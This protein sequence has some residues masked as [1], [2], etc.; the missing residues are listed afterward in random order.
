MLRGRTTKSRVNEKRALQSSQGKDRRC[1]EAGQAWTHEWKGD[2]IMLPPPV[3]H[4]VQR[5]AQRAPLVRIL[6]QI[7]VGAHQPLQGNREGGW[8]DRVCWLSMHAAGGCRGRQQA[9]PLRCDTRLHSS[10]TPQR[11]ARLHHMPA[12]R[13]RSKGLVRAYRPGVRQ[14]S[15]YTLGLP[16]SMLAWKA[17][18]AC[19]SRHLSG[20]SA[21]A[22]SLRAEPD[23]KW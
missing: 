3:P 15:P 2:P 23:R 9:K 21:T 17:S 20:C 13:R 18:L 8:G 6:G 19:P 5:A 4:P 14:A 10:A 7:L 22:I 11:A 12:A 16:S 1:Y